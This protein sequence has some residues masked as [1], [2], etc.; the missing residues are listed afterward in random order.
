M[1]DTVAEYDDTIARRVQRL[2]D[3]VQVGRPLWRYN[4]LWYDNPE[5]FQPRSASEPR[6]IAPGQAEAA[7]QRA[8]RQSSSGCHR[9]ALSSFPST[10]MW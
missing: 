3:G 5:L 10:P 9:P 6:R 7:Y 8:E 4:R 1:H 2:F